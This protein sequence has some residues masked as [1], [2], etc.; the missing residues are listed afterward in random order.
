MRTARFNGHLGDLV[1]ASGPGTPPWPHSPVTSWT[2][3]PPAQ[4]M[5]DRH[6]PPFEQND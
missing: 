2:N 3:A 4:R 5:L 6:P 1:S